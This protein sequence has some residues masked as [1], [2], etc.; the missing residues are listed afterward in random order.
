M[1]GY[2]TDAQKAADIERLERE[3][4]EAQAPLEAQ[5]AALEAQCEAL[6][7][8]V[9]YWPTRADYDS[10]KAFIDA[11]FNWETKQARAALAQHKGDA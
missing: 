7:K 4:A 9:H 3:I 10:D 8:V 5:I 11:C 6:A 2:T 1:I